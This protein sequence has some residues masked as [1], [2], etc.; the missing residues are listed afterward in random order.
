MDLVFSLVFGSLVFWGFVLF[1]F[2]I[3]RNMLVSTEVEITFCI[4]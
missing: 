4:C 1:C 2:L 3:V